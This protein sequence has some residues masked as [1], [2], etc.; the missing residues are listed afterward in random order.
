MQGASATDRM[1]NASSCLWALL[2]AACTVGAPED[3][4]PGSGTTDVA[5]PEPSAAIPTQHGTTA[6]GVP[7]FA[8]ITAAEPLHEWSL[9]VDGP[10]S[11]RLETRPQ[12]S[13]GS[14]VD[15]VI[16]LLD[17]EGRYLQHND[18]VGGTPWS[19]L[20]LDHTDE[21][22]TQYSVRVGGFTRDVLGPFALIATCEGATCPG[23]D[24]S[25][26]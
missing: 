19:G 6:W 9:R 18:D 5:G 25:D 13:G 2:F 26:R 15:T 16:Y 22:S 23:S 14:T 17:A 24:G 1:R 3:G 20:T 4:K 8:E 21:R 7:S 11:V 10:A 12:R